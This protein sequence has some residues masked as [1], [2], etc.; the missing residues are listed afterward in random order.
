[1]NRSAV[2]VFEGSMLSTNIYNKEFGS[3]KNYKKKSIGFS[4]SLKSILFLHFPDS[5][6]LFIGD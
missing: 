1:M 4:A 6:M 5:L 2:L 3:E